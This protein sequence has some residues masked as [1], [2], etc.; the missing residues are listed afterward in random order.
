[1]ELYH[2]IPIANHVPSKH[3]GINCKLDSAGF[4]TEENCQDESD[5][6]VE[7]R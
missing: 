2:E 1:M 4:S 7:N 6:V 3:K 5:M